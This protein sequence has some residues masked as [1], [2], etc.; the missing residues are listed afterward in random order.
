MNRRRF[1]QLTSLVAAGA[2]LPAFLRLRGGGEELFAAGLKGEFQKARAGGKPLLVFVIPE[3]GAL[4][5]SVGETFGT[6]L[7]Q[8]STAA[9][10]DVALAHVVCATAAELR[11]AFAFARSSAMNGDP[12]MVLFETESEAAEDASARSLNPVLPDA[13][14]FSW[15]S[16]ESFEDQTARVEASLRAR[17]RAFGACITAALVGDVARLDARAGQCAA[18][19][20][21]DDIERLKETQDVAALPIDLVDRAAAWLRQEMRD[22]AED[23][24]GSIE[25][26]LAAAAIARVR[27]TPPPGARWAINDGCGTE[28][29][30]ADDDDQSMIAC[31][32]GFTPDF[33]R[34]FL[35]FFFDH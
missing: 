33:S 2:A 15:E 31:G 25:S 7:N 21:D 32:M 28:I 18:I 1:L 16:E 11:K 12:M 23:R 8:A 10:A 19:L 3:D 35:H 17:N 5:W 9:M 6:F 34:R 4:K 13:L 20:S 22:G 14:V 30:G 26:A 27:E 29:E 24:R